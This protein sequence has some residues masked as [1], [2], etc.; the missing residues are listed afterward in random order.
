MRMVAAALDV[1]APA[2]Y[3]HVKN[4]RE[5]LDAMARIAVRRSA[6]D[7][8]E[9]PTAR[10]GLAGLAGRP[11]RPAAPRPCCATATGRRCSPEPTS[12]TRVMW[13]TVELTLR[14]LE[15]AGFAAEEAAAGLPDP[16]ALHRRIRHRGAGPPRRGLR[17]GDNPY[18]AGR[19]GSHRGPAR[20]PR[21]A[22]TGRSTVRRR[23]G[24]RIRVRPARR[25]SPE[26]SR[27][28]R[29][30]S[31]LASPSA[32]SGVNCPRAVAGPPLRRSR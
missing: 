26:S 32:G 30:L 27:P 9:A 31:R 18:R 25:S 21:T 20:Y 10:R 4:K 8:V 5:L 1:Q 16:V 22:A 29:G 13:R 3:W 7:G 2:L 12:T 6:V 17:R 11:G 19:L 28:A 14:T 15:D 23:S 24:R